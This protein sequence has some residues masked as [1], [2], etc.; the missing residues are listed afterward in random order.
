M[1]Q[2]VTWYKRQSWKEYN[3]LG[4]VPVRDAVVHATQRVGGHG[5]WSTDVPVSTESPGRWRIMSLTR[6]LRELRQMLWTS[7]ACLGCCYKA[8][9][10]LKGKAMVSLRE[11][12]DE[13]DGTNHVQ[14]KFLVAKWSFTY[15]RVFKKIRYE[16]VQV[17]LHSIE[18]HLWT[19]AG[20]SCQSREWVE[21]EKYKRWHL[22][23][24]DQAVMK[25]SQW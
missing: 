10:H 12:L 5:C 22:G 6:I 8:A 2:F 11:M 24:G 14:A 3:F 18:W 21:G 9:A 7:L 13:T 4:R 1:L 17:N 16:A 23:F 25:R 20:D 19:L 15:N